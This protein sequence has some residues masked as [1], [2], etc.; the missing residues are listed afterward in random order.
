MWMM[1]RR[2]QRRR[3]GS[4]TETFLP[5]FPPSLLLPAIIL[6]STALQACRHVNKP[7]FLLMKHFLYFIFI[8]F[9][10]QSFRSSVVYIIHIP[11]DL[12]VV[13]QC[14]RDLIGLVVIC[15]DK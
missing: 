14:G 8:Y 9:K 3:G 7:A 5:S 11:R 2:L 10:K 15:F 12:G 6:G 1:S 4:S 13:S